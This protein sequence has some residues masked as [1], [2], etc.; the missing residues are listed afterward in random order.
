MVAGVPVSVV[1]LLVD[2]PEPFEVDCELSTVGVETPLD[3]AFESTGA[4]EGDVPS[5]LLVPC[6]VVVEVL[7]VLEDG[8]EL[9]SVVVL[10]AVPCCVVVEVLDVLEDGIEFWSVVVL[11]VELA[12]VPAAWA[13][14][15][16]TASSK[17]ADKI[18][19]FFMWL[20]VFLP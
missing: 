7:E 9:W 10:S 11:P 15:T 17:I 8:I 6:C 1:S 18:N 16:L 5:V 20:L 19:P 14:A 12:P 13:K 4:L 2:E 3:C